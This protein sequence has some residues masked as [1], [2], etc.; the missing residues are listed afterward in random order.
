[1]V[2]SLRPGMEKSRDEL[3]KKLVELQYERNDVSFTRNKFRVRGDVVEIFPAAS[4]DSIIR[5]EFFG[6]EIDR[7]SEINPLTGELKA[8]LKH[9]AIYPASHY[10]V[11]GDKMKRLL[12]KLTGS[13]RK[14][15][16]IFVKTES[17]LRHND[18]NSVQ[19]TIWKCCRKSDFVRVSRTI[20]E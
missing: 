6:D 11:S 1:M 14:D 13:L 16:H 15:L 10:I 3:V 17:S 9:A 5:V 2:I 12:R 19:G 8:I 7:I 4:N 18:L 20:Q